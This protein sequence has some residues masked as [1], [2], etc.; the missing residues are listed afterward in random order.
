MID[1]GA[2]FGKSGKRPKQL[3][4]PPENNIFMQPNIKDLQLK[5]NNRAKVDREVCGALDLAY[6]RGEHTG[7]LQGYNDCLKGKANKWAKP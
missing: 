1:S 7:Y 3:P 6:M 4:Q 5:W 2:R